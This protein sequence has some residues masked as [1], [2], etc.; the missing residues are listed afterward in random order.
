MNVRFSREFAVI[1]VV[2]ALLAIPGFGL[3]KEAAQEW[4]IINPEGVVTQVA[5]IVLAPHPSSLEGKTVALRANGKHNS[6]VFLERIGE[7]LK[8]K[9]KDVRIIK[10]W[11]AVPE[12][13]TYPIKA[14]TVKKVAALKP[15][16]VM[17]SQAD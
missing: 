7:L 9:V 5:P 3:A 13:F 15:V 2:V 14:D 11:E 8:E 1:V 4:E 10:L 16:I 12:S 17:G 6:D